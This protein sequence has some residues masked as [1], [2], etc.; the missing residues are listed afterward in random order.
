[1]DTKFLQGAV[2][3]M[4]LTGQ[5]RNVPWE[6]PSQLNTVEEAFKYYTERLLD[7]EV[8][9]YIITALEEKI[10][11][12]T[13]ADIVT[14]SSVMNGIHTLDV[15][16]LVNPIVRELLMYVADATDTEYVES[17]KSIEKEK[18]VPRSVARSVVKDAMQN[19]ESYEPYNEPMINTTTPKQGLMSRGSM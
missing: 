16:F 9:D 18:R 14:T 7:E 19:I 5:P 4:S 10:D 3:G 1:M 12:E 13:L 2:P 17:Y 11:I 8:S 6:N 15:A